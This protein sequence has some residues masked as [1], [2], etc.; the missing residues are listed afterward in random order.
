MDKNW[1][2][3]LGLAL[4]DIS[5]YSDRSVS[6]DRFCATCHSISSNTARGWSYVVL[7]LTSAVFSSI[8][9]ICFYH[10]A[11]VITHPRTQ[12]RWDPYDPK[13]QDTLTPFIHPTSRSE[14]Y[15]AWPRHGITSTV[16]AYTALAL[17]SS[18]RT[19][20]I[21]LLAEEAPRH[22]VSPVWLRHVTSS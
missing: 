14:E 17:Q 1:T 15:L 4:H 3:K 22:K 20:P 10:M 16:N 8:A 6:I 2:L 12:S 19:I 21:A 18:T 13:F 7:M 9:T 5:E 11:D